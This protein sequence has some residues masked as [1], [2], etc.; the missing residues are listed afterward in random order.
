M[1]F[2]KRRKG[3]MIFKIIK[4]EYFNQRENCLDAEIEDSCGNKFKGLLRLESPK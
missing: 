1:G 2:I 4:C 3:A